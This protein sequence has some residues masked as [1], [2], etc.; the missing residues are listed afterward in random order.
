ME[1]YT[2]LR[3]Q[4]DSYIATTCFNHWKDEIDAMDTDNIELKLEVPV[5]IRSED[6]QQELP[7]AL[8]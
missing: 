8:V 7:A 6:N 1:K 4:L 2:K 5:L 3:D